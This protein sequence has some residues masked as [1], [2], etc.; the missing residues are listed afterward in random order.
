VT[1]IGNLWRITLGT[2]IFEVDQAVAGKVSTFSIDGTDVVAKNIA[3]TGSEF[4]T[5]PQ[6]GCTATGKLGRRRT[7]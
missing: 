1:K 7:R 6:N 2:V 3:A 5:S 4:W